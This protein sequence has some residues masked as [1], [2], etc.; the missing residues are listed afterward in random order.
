[1]EHEVRKLT[2]K[3]D[4][5]F[6]IYGHSKRNDKC[7]KLACIKNG[8]IEMTAKSSRPKFE[9][10]LNLLP[11]NMISKTENTDKKKDR[12]SNYFYTLGASY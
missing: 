2:E 12:H 10:Y 11:L 4:K 1:M 7:Q 5:I 3:N 8:L 6:T 9:R